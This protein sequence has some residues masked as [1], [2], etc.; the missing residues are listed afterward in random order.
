MLLSSKA[1]FI[2]IAAGNDVDVG[3]GL[4]FLDKIL[5]CHQYYFFI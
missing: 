5:S 4:T 1:K 2:G 3:G